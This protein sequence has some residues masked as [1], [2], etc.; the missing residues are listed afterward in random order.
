MKTLKLTVVFLAIRFHQAQTVV[1]IFISFVLDINTIACL[2]LSPVSRGY[3]TCSRLATSKLWRDRRK[4]PNRPGTRCF[5]KCP[6][7][8]QLRGEYDLTC[9]SDGTWDGLQDGKCISEYPILNH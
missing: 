9:R 7:G 1:S 2:P 6:R 3:L 5:L 4:E 8:Y